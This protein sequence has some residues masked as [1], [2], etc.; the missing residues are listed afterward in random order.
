MSLQSFHSSNI[1]HSD[2]HAPEA[3]FSR[4]PTMCRHISTRAQIVSR[5]S[6]GVGIDTGSTTV[7]RFCN[8]DSRRRSQAKLKEGHAGRAHSNGR[9]PGETQGPP[10]GRTLC[11]IDT[12][13]PSARGGVAGE[14]QACTCVACIMCVRIDAP[15]SRRV[16]LVYLPNRHR[17]HNTLECISPAIVAR[18][19]KRFA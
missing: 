13:T 6:V 8:G 16:S 15:V 2:A 4:A 12:R 10:H 7:K 17:A 19:L 14:M 11:L 1:F 5:S 18:G 9:Q 3:F